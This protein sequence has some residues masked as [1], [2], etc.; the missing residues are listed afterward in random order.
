MPC[1]LLS[2]QLAI[3]SLDKCNQLN[4]N[5]RKSSSTVLNQN[6]KKKKKKIKHDNAEVPSLSDVVYKVK[7]RFFSSYYLFYFLIGGKLLSNVVLVSAIQ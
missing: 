3:V 7:N 5:A 4:K 6:R 2:E 1:H